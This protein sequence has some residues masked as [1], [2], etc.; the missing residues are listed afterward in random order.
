MPKPFQATLCNDAA[1]EARIH[2]DLSQLT[3]ALEESLDGDLVSVLL[4]GGYARGEGSVVDHNGRLGPYNDYD[5]VVVVDRVTK[6]IARALHVLSETW[7]ARLGVEVDAWPMSR[8]DL[9]RAPRILLWLD[10]ALDGARVLFGEASVLDDVRRIQPRDIPATECARLLGNRATG[11]ALSNLEVD[12][13]LRR[14]RH[15]HKMILAL[16]DASLLLADRYAGRIAERAATLRALERSPQIGAEL[17]DAYE[18]AMRFRAR[19]DLWRPNGDLD[20]WYGRIRQLACDR[21]LKFEAMRVGTTATPLAYA[22]FQGSLFPT[23]HGVATLRLALA[24]ARANSKLGLRA[25]V[26]TAHP[27]EKL[28]RA[29][30][31]LAYEPTNPEAREKAANLLGIGHNATDEALH[32]ALRGMSRIGG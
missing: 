4:L 2:D 28:M 29:S 14:A 23:P 15:G 6:R 25:I 12:F 1:A 18:D 30:V 17:A 20:S 5:L 26:S 27:R 3:R 32:A 22:S 19:P 7:S 24:T 16:G 9:A 8:R 31:L 13:D 11:L 21:H 10:A